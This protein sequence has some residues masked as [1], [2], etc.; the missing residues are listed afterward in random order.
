MVFLILHQGC[1]QNSIKSYAITFW[2]KLITQIKITK[3]GESHRRSISLVITC[4]AVEDTRYHLKCKVADKCLQFPERVEVVER[5]KMAP[6]LLL[7]SCELLVLVEVS[8]DKW[9]SIRL[10]TEWLWAR[11]PLF[12]LKENPDRKK[13]T[14]SS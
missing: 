12:S 5:N 2:R 7:L 13:E 14:K 1:F 3:G 11:I 6:S 10:P 9:L 8:L 4:D